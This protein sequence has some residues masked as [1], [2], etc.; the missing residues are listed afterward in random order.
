MVNRKNVTKA[1][2]FN[3]KIFT[4][5]HNIFYFIELEIMVDIVFVRDMSFAFKIYYY[6]LYDCDLEV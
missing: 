5:M 6:L 1:F 2:V 4:K 3:R